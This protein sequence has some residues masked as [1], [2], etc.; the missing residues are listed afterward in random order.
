MKAVRDIDGLWERI[1]CMEDSDYMVDYRNPRSGR[2]PLL[3]PL[4]WLF[5]C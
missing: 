1:R 3:L 2:S 4:N 5:G